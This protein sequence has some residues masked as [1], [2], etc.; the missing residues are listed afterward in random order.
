[1]QTSNAATAKAPIKLTHVALVEGF[2]AIV[3]GLSRCRSLGIYFD[4]GRNLLYQNYSSNVVTML[5]YSNRHWLI[6]AEENNRPKSTHLQF[7]R[8]LR[9]HDQQLSLQLTKHI[10]YGDMQASRQLIICLKALQA[11][12]LLE[13]TKRQNGKT[14]MCV[15]N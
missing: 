8:Y 15:S 13:K 11:S 10:N 2:F 9:S 3:F 14:V 5:E 6:D 7:R 1:M 4:L 12:K